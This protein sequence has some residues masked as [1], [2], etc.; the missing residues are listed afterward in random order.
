MDT[1]SETR[2]HGTEAARAVRWLAQRFPAQHCMW[3]MPVAHGSSAAWDAAACRLVT[4]ATGV[5]GHLASM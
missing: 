1:G 4:A 3:E 2:V 5:P